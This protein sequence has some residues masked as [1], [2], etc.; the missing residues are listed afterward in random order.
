MN[1]RNR[2]ILALTQALAH[3]PAAIVRSPEGEPGGGGGGGGGAGVGEAKF[4]QEQ[5]NK[6]V[7]ERLGKVQDELRAAKEIAAK[8]TDLEKRLADADAEKQKAAD[9][10]EVKGKTEL[11]KIQIQLKK[12]QDAFKADTDKWSRERAEF[13][14]KLKESG[15]KLTDFVKR[16]HVLPHLAS[17]AADGAA[18]VAEMA[19]F[20]EAQI[21]L[22]ED[23]VLKSISVGGKSFEK[24][25]DAAKHFYSTAP[26]LAKPPT[27]G[28]AGSDRRPGGQIN[29]KS[30]ENSTPEEL[31]QAGL[32]A[33]PVQRGAIPGLAAPNT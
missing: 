7:Q 25:E 16:H 27:S 31:M 9:E 13:E 12:A 20:A 17:G 21:E 23:N 1:R 29:P 6:I 22:G 8:V 30:F 28:G 3:R 5:V 14:G 10:A 32:A 15:Q 4:T 11:E 18:K 24:A 19:F 2:S 33:P 26:Y